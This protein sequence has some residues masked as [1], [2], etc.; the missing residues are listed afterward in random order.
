V[1]FSHPKLANIISRVLL[2]RHGTFGAHGAQKHVQVHH[3]ATFTEAAEYVQ[4]RNQDGTQSQEVTI[5]GVET[6]GDFRTIKGTAAVHTHPF[7][8]D[9]AFVVR[10]D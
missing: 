6:V 5:F 3:C 10:T 8:G 2:G 4:V 1:R 7:I 9:S